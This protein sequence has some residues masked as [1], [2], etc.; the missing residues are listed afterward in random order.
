M[1]QKQHLKHKF[2]RWIVRLQ[3]YTYDIRHRA[4]AQNQLA[5]ALSRNPI[6]E[7]ST[8]NRETWILFSQQDVTKAQQADGRLAS[9]IDS[10]GDAGRNAKFV[11]RNGTLYRRHW[12][13]KSTECHLL[14]IPDTLRSSVLRAIHDTPEGGHVGYRATLRKAQER[15]LVA[16]KWIKACVHTLPVAR[17]VSNTNDVLELDMDFLRRSSLQRQFSTRW[18]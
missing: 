9:V 7:F 8:R 5:D 10:I 16:E 1:F 14:V 13:D 4:G 12:A 3:D 15:F 2:A 17:F 18:A 11:L 6:E